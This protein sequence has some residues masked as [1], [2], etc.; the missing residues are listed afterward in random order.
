MTVHPFSPRGRELALEAMGSQELDMLI[1]GGGITGCGLARDAALRGLKVALVEKE[2]FGY[3]T[4]SR[5]SKLVH[6]GVR[7]LANGDISMVKESARERKILKTIAPHLVHPL[8][9]VLPIFKGESMTKF[10][11]GLYV[12]DKLAGSSKKESHRVLSTKEL[13]EYAPTI[14]EPIKGGLKFDEYI[15]EDGRFTVMNA[16]SA[17]EHGAFVANHALAIRI[18][19]D[20]NERVIGAVVRD[21]MTKKEF[22]V[23]AKITINATGPWAEKTLLDSELSPPKKLLLSKGI[24]LI[25]S[26]SKIPLEGAI[27]L[28]S[29]D[30]KEGFAIRRWNYVYIG[31]TDV[32]HDEEVDCPKADQKAIMHLL[33]M[34]QNCFPNSHLTEADILGTWAG[35]RP[36]ILE[37]GKSA[38]DTSRHDEVWKIKEGLLTIAGGKLTTYR[39][40]ASRVMKEAATYLGLDA[41]SNDRTKT[42]V[43]PGGH[44]GKDY[45][46]FREEKRKLLR[47]QGISEKAADRLTWLY[48]SAI[49]DLLEYGKEDSFWLEPLA[50]EVP[51]IKGEIRLAVEKE[52]AHHLIDFMDRRAAILLFSDNHGRSAAEVAADI[53]GLFFGWSEEEKKRQVESYIEISRRHDVP[54]RT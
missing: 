51:A 11:T 23:T 9:F 47:M 3:G 6:G 27:S 19:M 10:R 5:S 48:G 29:A 43:L 40:M 20:E 13:R 17:A 35:L 54:V 34:A 39:K 1:I 8:P 14:R 26:A 36:L 15:T 53:M 45:P 21:E 41:G 18:N 49:D 50:P 16:L 44:I 42:V 31:T 33:D 32:P 46:S 52:M 22:N 30:G 38:R 25:F 7:Y 37:E 24:H 2:D 28:K 12:F 4:S